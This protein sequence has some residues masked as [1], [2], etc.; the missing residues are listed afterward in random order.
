MSQLSFRDPAGFCFIHNGRVLRGLGAQD[1][2]VV[3]R[4]L[5]GPSARR[6]VEQGKLIASRRLSA[7]DCEALPRDGVLSALLQS[8]RPTAVFEHPRIE[9]PSFPYEWPPE[10]LQAAAELTLDL[11]QGALD[12]GYSLKDATPYNVLFIGPRPV[13]IDLL[14]FEERQPGDPVWLP[15]AQFERTF[16][17]PLLANKYWGIPLAD[18]FLTHRDGLEPV[19][20]PK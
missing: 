1:L 8:R 9:F 15:A 11:A 19:S 10:M 3:E 14:S 18:I 7:A 12:D 17:L 6:L 5:E 13:F 4:F 16:V 20:I 2:P